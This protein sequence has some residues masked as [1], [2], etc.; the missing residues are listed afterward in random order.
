MKT[1][2]MTND[3]IVARLRRITDAEG[4]AAFCKREN[5]SMAY[6]YDTLRGKRL[7]GPKIVAAVGLVIDIREA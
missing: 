7:P 3:E 1:A 5:I 4:V 2:S 6:V